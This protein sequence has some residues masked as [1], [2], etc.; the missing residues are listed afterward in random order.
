MAGTIQ[1]RF[2]ADHAAPSSLVR[3][4]RGKH[5]TKEVRG[6]RLISLLTDTLHTQQRMASE[7]LAKILVV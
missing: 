5:A 4:E 3:A 7:V 2:G 6:A 1:A